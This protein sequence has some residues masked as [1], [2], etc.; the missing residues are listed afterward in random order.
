MM[1]VKYNWETPEVG[2]PCVTTP[3]MVMTFDGDDRRI[4]MD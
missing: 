2:I 4:D 3:D 1:N